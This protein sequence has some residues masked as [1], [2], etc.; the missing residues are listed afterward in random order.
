M[1]KMILMMSKCCHHSTPFP[2]QT[3]KTAIESNIM[4]DDS[5]YN[6]DTVTTKTDC[7]NIFKKWFLISKEKSSKMNW[8]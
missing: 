4:Y 1:L 2:V 6:N 5:D 7:L 8:L 3:V